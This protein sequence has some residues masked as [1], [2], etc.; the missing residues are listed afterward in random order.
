MFL[1]RNIHVGFPW[2][3]K[4]IT[5]ELLIFEENAKGSKFIPDKWKEELKKDFK[6]VDIIG[7]GRDHGMKPIYWCNK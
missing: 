2:W 7:Y 1:S 3:V 5:K 6:S 4:R